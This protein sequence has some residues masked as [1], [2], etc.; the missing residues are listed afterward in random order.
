L[1]LVAQ[2]LFPERLAYDF[3]SIERRSAVFADVLEAVPDPR[4]DGAS[5]PPRP[6]LAER[7]EQGDGSGQSKVAARR[8]LAYG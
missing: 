3:G 4:L 2:G 8:S 1:P 5:T 7:A 6:Q